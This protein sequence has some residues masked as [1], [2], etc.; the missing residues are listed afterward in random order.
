M[1]SSPPTSARPSA[2][3]PA[4]SGFRCCCF[5]LSATATHPLL[6][7][8][9][10]LDGSTAPLALVLAGVWLSD[11][12]LGVMAS[13]LLA[14]VALAAALL[15]VPGLRLRARRLPPRWESRCPPCI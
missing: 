4:A 14:A 5:F 11:A 9:R 10:A 13:Y 3:L 12:P 7:W 6:L 8:R 15:A 1:P 2:S